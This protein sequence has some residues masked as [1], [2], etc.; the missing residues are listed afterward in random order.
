MKTEVETFVCQALPSDLYM[1][2]ISDKVEEL[3]IKV[4]TVDELFQK[5]CPDQHIKIEEVKNAMVP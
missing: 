1:K 5:L 3:G 2:A 4:S